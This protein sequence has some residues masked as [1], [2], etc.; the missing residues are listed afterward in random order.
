[1]NRFLILIFSLF[2]LSCTMVWAEADGPDYYR[3]H[4]VASDDVLNVH[5]AAGSHAGKVGEIPPNASC[6]INL[7]CKGGLTYDE[8]THLSKKKQAAILKKRP[9]WCHVRYQNI[10]GWVSAHFLAEGDCIKPEKVVGVIGQQLQQLLEHYSSEMI[11]SDW[12]N[13]S[14]YEKDQWIASVYH[15][16]AFSPYWV[17]E[18]GPVHKAQLLLQALKNSATEGLNPEDYGLS[19]IETLWQRSDAEGYAKLDILLTVAYI[20]YITDVRHGRVQP[21][22]EDEALFY[23]KA[24]KQIDPV[25]LIKEAQNSSGFNT[26]LSNQLPSHETY[27]FTRKGLKRYKEIASA[28]GWPV[29]ASGVTIHPGDADK[30]LSDIRQRLII[31]GDLAADSS[32]KPD[33]YDDVLAEAVKHFQV[34]HG[35]T[36]DGVIGKG[37]IS[38]MNVPADYRVQQIEM[39]LERW[40][41]IDHDLGQR[42]VVVDIP[43][44]MATDFQHDKKIYEMPVIVGK[45][46]HETPVFSEDIKYV[47]LNPYWTLTPHIARTET[48]HKLRKDRHYLKKNH[49]SLFRG[50]HDS[51]ELD[52]TRINWHKVS[53]KEMN[54]Y[55]FR[56]N[57]G[58]W[59]ALGVLKIVFPNAHSVY[60]HDTPN[61][62]L[63]EREK[64][65]FSHGCI[66]MDNPVKQASV[67]L[68]GE[69]TENRINDVIATG[70]R[71]VV[72]LDQPM[73]VHLVYQTVWGD[74][75]GNINFVRDIYKRDE[76]LHK[77]L[78]L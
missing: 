66:R 39:N 32:Q 13:I 31:S 34:R 1:M 77:A 17:T 78:Y 74:E 46:H 55:R 37:T 41:W 51:H 15:D 58:P 4:G 20:E 26:F 35:M 45:L 12:H 24:D 36:A 69:W 33:F 48:L 73:K 59:N 27:R 76:R 16:S 19:A 70:K 7:G 53:P 47:V 64:R 63:F 38:A 21:K 62:Q 14:V 22:N 42:Y 43:S 75:N 6:V 40:R 44:F 56:Q 10:E 72:R 29:I 52:A 18:R 60:M 8:F 65:G 25:A 57:P 30:R 50:W 54:K 68:G 61:H 67:V 5:N 49:I 9:R 3:V 23:H 11:F 28:G 71:T 2:M